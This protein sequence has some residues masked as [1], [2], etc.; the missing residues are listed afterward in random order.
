MSFTM[1]GALQATPTFD[2]LG[3][4]VL[5]C[6]GALDGLNALGHRRRGP[7]KQKHIQS[8]ISY[9][10]RNF[11]RNIKLGDMQPSVIL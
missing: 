7:G 4:V 6:L 3:L 5:L 10:V 1:I 11:L 9:F 2:N 8:K